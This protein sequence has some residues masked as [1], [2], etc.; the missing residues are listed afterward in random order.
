MP[1]ALT[2][3]MTCVAAGLLAGFAGCNTPTGGPLTLGVKLVTEHCP[4]VTSWS[5]SPLQASAPN[6]KIAVTAETT[7]V[8]DAGAQPLEVMWS[9]T[10]GSFA[11]PTALQTVY[12]CT[13]IGTQTLTFSATD[14]HR[15]KPCADVV[16]MTVACKK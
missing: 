16:T 15:S 2:L 14:V 4:L 9:A 13:T 3:S 6:G 5:A 11:E 10:A 8:P 12:T 7:D 1:K